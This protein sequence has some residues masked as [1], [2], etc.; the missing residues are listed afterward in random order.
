MPRWAFSA[1]WAD[2]SSPRCRW[3]RRGYRARARSR[4]VTLGLRRDGAPLGVESNY[5]GG[6]RGQNTVEVRLR[7]HHR[8]ARVLEHEGQPLLRI[9]RIEG[10]V[11]SAGLED[12]VE[13]HDHL[14]RALHAHTHEHVRPDTALAQS[15]REL[16]GACVELTIGERA[17]LEDESRRVRRSRGLS[18]EDLVNA[19]L[20]GVSE[21]RG[22]PV[23]EDS[24]ALGVVEDGEI[25]HPTLGR[26][27]E[28]GEQRAQVGFHPGDRR[29]IEEI[30]RVLDP[31][32]E[33]A[34]AIF[35]RER[36]I[37]L[38]SAALHVF[39]RE[40]EAGER[41]RFAPA[42]GALEREHHLEERERLRSR[43]GSISCTR[44]SKGTS[45]WA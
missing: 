1:P 19:R 40:G 25:A 7:Q 14:D 8:N 23:D 5:F 45:W 31:A 16:V 4:R 35:H 12:A 2:P 28:R 37:E 21:G 24:T 32:G 29:G 13:R 10:H 43:S 18:L 36:E 41:Q 34:L 17:T 26:L 33:I 6:V 44:R 9:L 3:H 20:L 11:S 22:I 27:D 30:G 42:R 39:A 38:R 15:V